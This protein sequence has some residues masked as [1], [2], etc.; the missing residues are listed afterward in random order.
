MGHRGGP[1]VWLFKLTVAGFSH[2]AR[3]LCFISRPRTDPGRKYANFACHCLFHRFSGLCAVTRR[4]ITTRS[5]NAKRGLRSSPAYA[6]ESGVMMEPFPALRFGRGE[7][8]R[9]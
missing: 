6:R 9:L 8:E 2:R 4:P 1:Q 5:S 3:L 7:T